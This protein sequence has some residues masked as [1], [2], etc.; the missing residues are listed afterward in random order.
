MAEITLNDVKLL[1]GDSSPARRA[2]LAQKLANDL[3]NKT[4]SE[5]EYD[6]AI[7]I[8]QK[9][10]DD[11]DTT[12]RRSLSHALKNNNDIPKDLAL[13]LAKDILEVSLPM[14]EFSTLLEDSDLIE[15][16]H[17][18]DNDRQMAISHRQ[19]LSP[20][21]THSLCEAGSEAVV[22]S[23]LKNEGASFEDN[24]YELVL[25]RFEKSEAI[26]AGLATRH[27]LPPHIIDLL[28]DVVSDQLKTY[29]LSH[30]KLSPVL[31]ERVVLESREDAKRRLLHDPRSKRDA[32]KLVLA[33]NKQGKLTPEL[34]FRA[35]EIGDRPFFEYAMAH[36]VGIDI[37]AARTLIK[38]PGEKG[39]AALYK[40][41]D[42]PRKDFSAINYLVDVEYRSHSHR[43]I[44][45]R[46]KRDANARQA[47]SWLTETETKKKKWRLF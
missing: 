44:T 36:R 26:H 3:K 21:L 14:L 41:A 45:A 11:V 15:I 17:T 46:E 18:G 2:V 8:C 47:E 16:I 4:L 9:L 38:D 43:P 34:I 19:T 28:V 22:E 30:Q 1:D 25:Q 32:E 6:L 31:I 24:T 13:G 12:V 20:S 29:L 37:Q 5:T 42:L 39:F 40:K 27:Q 33:M 7:A 10:A 35:L 23:T